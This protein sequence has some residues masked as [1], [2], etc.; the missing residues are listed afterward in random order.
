[1]DLDRRL[2][3]PGRLWI[4]SALRLSVLNGTVLTIIFWLVENETE[5]SFFNGELYRAFQANPE[6]C[7]L[8][9]ALNIV[10]RM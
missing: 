7:R 4:W 3:K 5:A 6:A 1:M 2:K 10:D 9:F 8:T